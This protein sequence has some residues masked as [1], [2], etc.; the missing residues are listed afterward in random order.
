[1]TGPGAL[2]ARP[3]PPAMSLNLGLEPPAPTARSGIRSPVTLKIRQAV[4]MP[5]YSVPLSAM[6]VGT[7]PNIG[8]RR[9]LM[10]SGSGLGIADPALFGTPQSSLFLMAVSPPS[11]PSPRASR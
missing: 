7:L 5:K 4:L 9:A 1:M 2:T 10:V 6:R 11:A 3:S 8:W